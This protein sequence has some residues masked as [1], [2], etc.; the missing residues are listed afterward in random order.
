[1]TR[2]KITGPAV[3][4]IEEILAYIAAQSVQTALLVST[5]FEKAFDR[6]VD[7]PNLGHRREELKDANA[8]V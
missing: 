2:Y 8:R 7:M 6:V 5:R 4:D 1:V 3:R